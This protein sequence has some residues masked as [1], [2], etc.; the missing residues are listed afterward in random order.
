MPQRRRGDS[1]ARGSAQR[2]SRPTPGKMGVGQESP[3]C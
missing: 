3:P 2:H 1:H